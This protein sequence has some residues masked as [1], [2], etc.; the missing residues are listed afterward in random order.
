MASAAL[1]NRKWPD[2]LRASASARIEPEETISSGTRSITSPELPLENRSRE[3]GQVRDI[4]LYRLKNNLIAKILSYVKG[5]NMS[6]QPNNLLHG[7]TLETI[8]TQLVERYGWEEL[9]SQIT[10]KCFTDDP[11]IKSSLKFLRRT[12][13][14][15]KKVEELYVRPIKMK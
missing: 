6:G 9:G 13:W 5:Q 4:D 15:R 14:A 2:F 12:P 11:S 7:V 3:A 10:I 1:V 8:L